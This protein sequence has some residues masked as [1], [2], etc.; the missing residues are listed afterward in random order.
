MSTKTNVTPSPN[1]SGGWPLIQSVQTEL[2]RVFDHFN[3]GAFG[4]NQGVLLAI[5]VA[6]TDDAIEVTAEIPGVKSEDLDVSISN[7]T[8]ILKGQ[9]SDTREDSGKDWRTV[10][11]S[12]GSFSRHIP[13]GFAPEDG[14]VD[15]EFLEGVLTLRIAKPT[16]AP[17]K[18]RKIDV[19][20]A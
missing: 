17:A 7:E 4:T 13:L 3:A 5:D 14:K 12:F 15:V 18:S 1:I 16:D 10:E 20:A 6:E 9:K 19:T 8:L 11:R 2:N